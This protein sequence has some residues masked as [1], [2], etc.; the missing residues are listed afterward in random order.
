MATTE[1]P[2]REYV[3]MAAAAA[4]PLSAAVTVVGHSGAGAFLPAIGE[5]IKVD[6]ALLFV[7]AVIPPPVLAHT[8]PARMKDL[9]DEQTDDGILR[10]WLAWWPSEVVAELLPDVGDRNELAADMPRLPRSFYDIEVDVPSGWSDEA[11][12]YLRLSAGYNSELDE[13]E[14]RHWPTAALASTHLGVYTEPASVLA[15]IENLITQIT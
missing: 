6:T 3:R 15:A 4:G 1:L 5:K 13:A 14:A 2:H 9:L 12:A 8:T 11:C 7:D 10:P